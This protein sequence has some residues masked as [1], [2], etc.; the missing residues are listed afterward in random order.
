[1][2]DTD[3]GKP[4]KPGKLREK[5]LSGKHRE[6]TGKNGPTLEKWNFVSNMTELSKIASNKLNFLKKSACGGQL[7]YTVQYYYNNIDI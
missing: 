7:Q 5:N 2:V 4:G 3:S 1:M 6:N